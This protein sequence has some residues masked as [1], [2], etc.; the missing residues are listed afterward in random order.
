VLLALVSS[1]GYKRTREGEGPKSLMKESNRVG[2]DSVGSGSHPMGRPVS[3][4]IGQGEGK[5]YMRERERGGKGL[6]GSHRH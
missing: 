4:F 3:P 2:L 1:R 6:L 5:S